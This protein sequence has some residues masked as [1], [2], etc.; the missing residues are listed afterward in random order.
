MHDVVNI[1]ATGLQILTAV[2]AIRLI[3]LTHHR[4]GW[5]LLALASSI[6]ALRRAT[7]LA[8]LLQGGH[9][10]PSSLWHDMLGMLISGL[11]LGAV[12]LIR[13]QFIDVLSD[14]RKLAAANQRLSQLTAKQ[15]FTLDHTNDFIFRQDASG[16]LQYVSASV[17]R[18]T[19]Y[20]PADWM[21]HF[22]THHTD[23][24]VNLISR[25]RHEEMLRTG[26]A[27]QPYLVEQ[28]HANGSLLWLEIN[29]QP[30]FVDGKVAGFVG[31]ARD[32]T[33]RVELEA[34][35]DKLVADLQESLAN[36]RVLKGLLPIC[37]WCKKIRDDRGY[38]NQLE[39]YVTEHSDAS[40][41]HGICPE[42][43]RTLQAQD[44]ESDPALDKA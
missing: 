18:I 9:V 19:G 31:V 20:P 15:E 32:A 42:C 4:T 26:Q 3:P 35:R 7:F 22:S 39:A 38:W 1:C 44:T 40:F 36:V 17:E 41:S 13:P 25:E 14:K 30:Y 11:M 27:S 8:P 43:V 28:R 24:P 21:V 16:M 10:P 23:N 29:K 5:V 37:A 33:H 6:T 34:Q 12:A 2:L